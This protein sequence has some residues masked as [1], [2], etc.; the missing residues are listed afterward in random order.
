MNKHMN[1]RINSN[2]S[3]LLNICSLSPR[4]S[5][6]LFW[7]HLLEILLIGFCWILPNN[8]TKSLYLVCWF[9]LFTMFFINIFFWE[10]DLEDWSINPTTYLWLRWL[11]GLMYIY[12]LCCRKEIKC[13]DIQK[14]LMYQ[15]AIHTLNIPNASCIMS[16]LMVWVRCR[17]LCWAISLGRFW[18][19]Q[20]YQFHPQCRRL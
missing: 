2:I 16:N 14:C 6:N 11:F 18:R 15:K 12:C 20:L 1:Y 17:S 3:L 13:T 19:S 4:L 10:I 8:Y 9:L 7:L 5:W